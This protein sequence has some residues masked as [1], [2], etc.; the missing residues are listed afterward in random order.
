MSRSAIFSAL[1]PA[2]RGR[3]VLTTTDIGR[4]RRRL[5]RRPRRPV[6]TTD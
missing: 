5:P 6:I 4:F 1:E 2:V 3:N